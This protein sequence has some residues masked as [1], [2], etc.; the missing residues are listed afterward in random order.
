MSFGRSQ[1]KS[2]TFRYGEPDD[3]QLAKDY[4]KNF[5]ETFTYNK[6][7]DSK[8]LVIL[9]R[10]HYFPLPFIFKHKLLYTFHKFDATIYPNTH[11]NTDVKPICFFEIGQ[12]CDI[13]VTLPDGKKVK[14]KK[15]RHS[16]K[17]QQIKDGIIDDFVESYFPNVPLYRPEKSDC[18]NYAYLW[19]NYKRY[20]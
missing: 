13:T 9:E 4:I 12:V 14:C 19:D 3:H 15:S 17:S 20:V 2:Y 16:K 1:F 10:K 6:F 11:T 7:G 18:L 8:Y 5:F